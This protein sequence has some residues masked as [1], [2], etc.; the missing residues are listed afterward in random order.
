[1][2][3]LWAE[4]QKFEIKIEA[5]FIGRI[6][7]CSGDVMFTKKERFRVELNFF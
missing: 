6:C 4:H 7:E 1:M 5:N 3:S 2:K